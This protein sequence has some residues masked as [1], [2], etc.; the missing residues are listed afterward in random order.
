[1]AANARISRRYAR[2]HPLL[3][4]LTAHTLA[5][6]EERRAD[7]RAGRR[8][9][10]SAV[11]RAA[12]AIYHRSTNHPT[13]TAHD[14]VRAVVPGTPA[15]GVAQP[16]KT[17]L[18]IDALRA[19]I[20]A[21]PDDLRGLRDRAALLVGWAP[22]ELVAL[23]VCDLRFEPEGVAVNHPALEN[24]PRRRQCNGSGATVAVPFETEE[25]NCPVL[26]L[27]RWLEA[28]GP[29]SCVTGA[30]RRAGCTK[31]HPPGHPLG[32]ESCLRPWASSPYRIPT[33]A[34]S[35]SSEAVHSVAVT[36]LENDSPRR[37]ERTPPLST[38]LFR[39]PLRR[40][41]RAR[42]RALDPKRSSL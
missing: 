23:E 16:Q 33:V 32:R 2:S 36:A 13:P 31:V 1:M 39:L 9:E 28:A 42:L 35:E 4:V 24:R 19:V 34:R 21:I 38:A 12:I 6:I 17:A 10:P 30:G 18:E 3:N 27:R 15:S 5:A 22:A 25:R 14:V 11:E 41:R 20:A 8:C 26:A 29:R 37:R 40:D 7:V